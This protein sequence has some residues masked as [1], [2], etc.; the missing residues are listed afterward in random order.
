M[1]DLNEFLAVKVMGWVEHR[2][3]YGEPSGDQWFMRTPVNAWNPT[4]NI[5]QA[6]MCALKLPYFRIESDVL[7]SQRFLVITYGGRKNPDALEYGNDLTKTL[8]L[9]C[10]R[11]KGWIND[12]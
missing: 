11:A 6:M 8:S 1:S 7:E 12:E 10:A 9:A 3:H 5:A 4:E 2:N